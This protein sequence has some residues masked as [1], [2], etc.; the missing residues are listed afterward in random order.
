MTTTICKFDPREITD[1][2]V[3]RW[4]WWQKLAEAGIY[5]KELYEASR[6][7]HM[8]NATSTGNPGQEVV[9]TR[10]GTLTWVP[11]DRRVVV[12]HLNRKMQVMLTAILPPWDPAKDMAKRYHRGRL[13]VHIA[14]LLAE[15]TERPVFSVRAPVA[16]E[17]RARVFGLL[18]TT[19]RLLS[20]T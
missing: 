14:N 5:V 2:R 19:Q 3:R 20:G 11:N 18:G 4:R 17:L 8:V 13:P 7:A 12:A 10:H 6:W 16:E 15:R 1:T 9:R